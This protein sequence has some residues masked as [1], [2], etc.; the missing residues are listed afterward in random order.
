MGQEMDFRV[1]DS[2]LDKEAPDPS[3]DPLSVFLDKDRTVDLQM[4]VFRRGRGL[5]LCKMV[6]FTKTLDGRSLGACM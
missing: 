6:V 4:G 1:L 2:G 5:D 3:V